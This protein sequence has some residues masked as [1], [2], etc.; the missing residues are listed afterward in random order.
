MFHLLSHHSAFVKK[1]FH[2]APEIRTKQIEQK[3]IKTQP[4]HRSSIHLACPGTTQPWTRR[5]TSVTPGSRPSSPSSCSTRSPTTP[6]P[7]V[8]RTAA[9]PSSSR[10]SQRSRSGDAIRATWGSAGSAISEV[11]GEA[12]LNKSAVVTF[13]DQTLHFVVVFSICSP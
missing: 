8:C 12:K 11:Q 4:Y 2:Y 1:C 5:S 9:A 13:K 6:A 3:L 7:S 10:P